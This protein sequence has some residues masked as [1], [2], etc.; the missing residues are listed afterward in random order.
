MPQSKLLPLFSNLLSPSQLYLAFHESDVFF[1]ALEFKSLK[2]SRILISPCCILHSLF[3]LEEN[4]SSVLRYVISLNL[5]HIIALTISFHM[6]LFMNI[7]SS[8]EFDKWMQSTEHNIVPF[9]KRGNR[10]FKIWIVKISWVKRILIKTWIKTRPF[11]Q[12]IK[13]NLD[14]ML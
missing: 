2:I 11:I 7:F 1:I 8:L 10:F 13:L 14:G 3:T 4:V 12:R 6:A 5:H 9:W